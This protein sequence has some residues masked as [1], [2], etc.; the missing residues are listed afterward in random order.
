MRPTKVFAQEKNVYYIVETVTPIL[1]RAGMYPATMRNL[2]FL[3]PN[4]PI[5][6]SAPNQSTVADAQSGVNTRRR[7]LLAAAAMTPLAVAASPLAAQ[8][9]AAVVHT[10]AGDFTGIQ[11]DGIWAYKGIRY[12]Q[13]TAAS[14][15]A[16][17][18]AAPPEKM[19]IRAWEFAPISPQRGSAKG[20]QSEDCL[21]LNIWTGAPDVRA[22]KTVMVY[23]H[24]GAYATGS[25]NDAETDGATLAARG[26]VVVVTI[27]HRLNVFGYLYLGAGD[28]RFPDSGNAGQLDLVLA[29]QWIRR[30]I[31]AFGGDANHVMVFGQSGGGAKIA[32]LMAMP[33]AKGL[34][35]RAATMSGQQVTA[36]GPI[37][38][39]RRTRAYLA[40]LQ[41]DPVTAPVLALVEA[42]SAV[43]PVLGGQV[44]FGPVL[45]NRTLLRHPFYPDAH[46]QGNSIPMMLGNTIAE[47]RA[48]FPPGHAKLSGLNWQNIAEGIEPELRVDIA[49]GMVVARYRQWFPQKS[50]LEIFIAA[51]TDSRSWRAQVIEA[52]ERARAGVPAFVYQLDFEDAAHT[53]DIA[54]VFGTKPG[55]SVAQRA[56]SG[57]MMDAFVAFAKTGNP[58][59]AAYTLP[60]RT[61]MIFDAPSRLENDPRR[62]Q[63]ELFATVPYVQPGT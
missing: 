41:I 42:L 1:K 32:T 3:M 7:R 30:H 24:G 28:A 37:N 39:Q 31:A 12:G 22:K 40:K 58:G 49:A 14:R 60:A 62:R 10:A 25:G 44:Y 17:P 26:D 50:P 43:D 5:F 33:A 34:F 9:I 36:S 18:L 29:L 4:G 54:L 27:T 8:N 57:K 2:E 19:P 56:M 38:A 61:T 45:D 63:R 6:P 48:F 15:F 23:I 52:E 59:W 53:A 55:M 46:P 51:T 13:D 20:V 35:H 16:P 47:T 21:F 11:R